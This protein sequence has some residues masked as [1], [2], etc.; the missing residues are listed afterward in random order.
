MS[1][2][3]PKTTSQWRKR[4]LP[5][6]V[7]FLAA[8]M[9]HAQDEKKKSDGEEPINNAPSMIGKVPIWQLKPFDR[10]YLK[11]EEKTVIDAEPD[12][13]P[14]DIDLKGVEENKWCGKMGLPW[15]GTQFRRDIWYRFMHSVEGRK[16]EVLGKGIGK[17][18]HYEDIIFGGLLGELRRPEEE[19][20]L[21]KFDDC[22]EMLRILNERQ[23]EN[24]RNVFARIR[25]HAMEARAAEMRQDWERGFLALMEERKLQSLV[26]KDARAPDYVRVLDPIEKR[27]GELCDSWTNFL[28]NLRKFGDGR[29][30]I[31]RLE[32]LYPNHPIGGKWRSAYDER[33]RP[34]VARAE[35]QFANGFFVEALAT[36]DTAVDVQPDHPAMRATMEKVFAKHPRMRVAVGELPGY[37]S[38]PAGWSPADIR[39]SELLHE[40]LMR[41][42]GSKEGVTEFDSRLVADLD[43]SDLNRRAEVQIVQGLSWPDGKPVTP[44]DVQRLFADARTKGGVFFHPALEFLLTNVQSQ[45]P[46]IV[47]IEFDRPQFQAKAWLQAPFLRMGLEASP[48]W[49]GMGPFVARERRPD[50][51][52]YLANLKYLQS[53]RPIIKQFV[54]SKFATPE[55][56]IRAIQMGEVEMVDNVPFRNLPYTKNLP[57]VKAVKIATPKVNL[58]QFNFDRAALRNPTLRRALVYAIDRNAVLQKVGAAEDKDVKLLTGA[59]PIGA[60]GYN[61][62]TQP[63]TYEPFLSK[64]LTAAVA[65]ELK[66]LPPFTFAHQGNEST[67]LACEEIARQWRAAGFQINLIEIDE[68][69]PDP[70]D[71]DIRY[72]TLTVSDPIFDLITVVTRDNPSLVTNAGPRLR[73]YLIDLLQTPNVT[74]AA[75]L[76]PEIHQALRDEVAL[77]PLWQWSETC[78]VSDAVSSMPNP[79]LRTYQNVADWKVVP[80][81]PPAFWETKP[82][83]WNPPQ[84]NREAL[85]QRQELR[86]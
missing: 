38:G 40:R 53:G 29:R 54:E 71:A 58:L 3:L 25:Y 63:W 12:R 9:I 10:L 28:V 80:R 14:K 34:I 6:F 86:P 75:T 61:S 76:L 56:R 57:G 49:V 48:G 16:Y 35:Q 50:R 81:Y 15:P 47:T 44:V 5:A 72:Q 32:A 52:T 51:I 22:L 43:V 31:A 21:V 39:A 79:L 20:K 42:K 82:L 59:L 8:G 77:I 2:P 13:L 24:A 68:R 70:R 27:V 7:G 23:P 1:Q 64:V 17:I 65:K 33:V 55:E 41:V 11:D 69:S 4:W 73:Q 66:A 60:F 84:S 30:V 67:R 36:L 78:L 83:A 62:Q 85:A 46:D 26:P 45:P 74:V 37:H 18:E 19:L